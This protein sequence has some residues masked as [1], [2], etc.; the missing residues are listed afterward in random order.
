MKTEEKYEERIQRVKDAVALKE[1]DRVPITP[2]ADIF[3][4]ALQVG[5]THKDVMYKGRKI[6]K[7]SLK[8]FSRYD[9]DLY[10]YMLFAGMGKIFDLV[11]NRTMKWAGAADPE[12]RLGDHQPYQI[13]EKAW[14]TAE[15]YESIKK[16]IIADTILRKKLN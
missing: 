8:V 15:E 4:A 12:F 13:I 11:G 10:P 14:M 3:F 9:W 16:F 7:A 1:P 6:G 5:M 2:F